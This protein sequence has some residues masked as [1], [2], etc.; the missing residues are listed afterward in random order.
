MFMPEISNQMGFVNGK[1]PWYLLCTAN[2]LAQ[3]VKGRTTV[4]EVVGSNPDRTKVESAAF[5]ITS[6]SG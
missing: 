3:L 4:R 2:Q 5:V 1:H 6:A